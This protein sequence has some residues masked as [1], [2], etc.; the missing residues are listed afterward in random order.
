MVL[1]EQPNLLLI[2][3]PGLALL[4]D[5]MGRNVHSGGIS[6]GPL[7]HSESHSLPNRLCGEF[8]PCGKVS[9]AMAVEE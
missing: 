7:S 3:G 5:V 6:R 8:L 9:E 4:V 1:F 2:N